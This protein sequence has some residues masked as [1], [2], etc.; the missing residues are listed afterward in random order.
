MNKE[1]KAAFTLIELLVVVLI[2][3]ILA[4]VAVP[5]YT[6]AVN[7]S[8]AVQ[9]IT[10]LKAIADAQEV[11]YL[12][13]G[14]Y[15][16]DINELDVD[17]PENLKGNAENYNV[18]ESDNPNQY[19]FAC[20][21]K[22]SCHAWATNPD[23]PSFEFTLKHPQTTTSWILLNAGKHFCKITQSYKTEKAKRI[24]QSLGTQD[25]TLAPF[26]ASAEGKYF[27]IN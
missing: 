21:E 17:V 20:V 7:K 19:I 6:Q 22:R 24:C 11:Y 3:G 14:D 26:N 1:T 16:E 10:M 25:D 23:V 13:H 27:L 2:I 15:A 4:A 18:A 12:S 9:A 5:Q 8:R